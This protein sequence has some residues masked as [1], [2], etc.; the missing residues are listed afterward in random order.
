MTSIQMMTELAVKIDHISYLI[1][2][3]GSKIKSFRPAL[4]LPEI[5]GKS[6]F[7]YRTH[8]LMLHLHLEARFV[9]LIIRHCFIS[10]M[11]IPAI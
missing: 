1:P 5:S 2:D 7:F 4:H 11:P 10:T 8:V 6:K 3:F 9:I